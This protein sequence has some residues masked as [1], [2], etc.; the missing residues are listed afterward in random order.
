MAYF[1]RLSFEEAVNYAGYLLKKSGKKISK[2]NVEY[3]VK[4]VGTDLY[5]IV[6]EIHKIVFYCDK[7]EIKVEDMK[8]VLTTNVQQNIFDLVNAIG[9]KREKE[10][11]RVLNALLEKG[12]MPLIIL[13]MIVRQL[14][15]IAKAKK[16]DGKWVDKKTF[17]SY[18]G[19]PYFAVDELMRQ[20]SL[21][22]KE[23]LKE[24][25]RECLKCDIALK[26]GMDSDLALESL[27]KKLCK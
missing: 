3:L 11:Y 20:S 7:E 22:K 10:A 25:Y 14:R 19:I 26:S 15:L 4:N 6:N 9:M 24:A 8:E 23:D 18:V 1:Q 12:E 16:F 2:A 27:I 21:F 5:A 17:A 13:T